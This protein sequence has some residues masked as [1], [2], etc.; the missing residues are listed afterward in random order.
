MN[1]DEF[2][3]ALNWNPKNVWARLL[4]LGLLDNCSRCGGS[5]NYS[6]CAMYGTTCFK[7]RGSKFQLP[8]LTGKLARLV[9]ERV[10]A[11]G[12]VEYFLRQEQIRKAKAELPALLAQAE[13]CY[14]VIGKPYSAASMA[15]NVTPELLDLQ[16]RN[17]RLYWG[18]GISPTWNR[19]QPVGVREVKDMAERG[20]CQADWAADRI[21]L[22]IQDLA[23]P[24]G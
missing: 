5:G 11:G 7:C 2:A 23:A 6:R 14:Y 20:Q 15:G 1:K 24:V 19:P 9:A 3:K 21:R 10:E 8:R 4:A 17:N 18:H 13:A 12:L 22:L 16:E